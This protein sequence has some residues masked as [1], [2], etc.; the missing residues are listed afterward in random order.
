VAVKGGCLQLEHDSVNRWES[1]AGLL[2]LLDLY[3]QSVTG[4]PT[5]VGALR[6]SIVA[7]TKLV[8][9]AADLPRRW[10]GLMYQLEDRWLPRLDTQ[11]LEAVRRAGT[12]S[13][14]EQLAEM[15]VWSGRLHRHV[16]E[17]IRDVTALMPWSSREFAA[18]AARFG[19]LPAMPSFAELPQ[20]YDLVAARLEEEP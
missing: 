13:D 12:D 1:F 15:A 10:P 17:V 14:H 4:L 19:D 9:E 11:L 3:D 2:T 6:K 5:N 18:A 20:L 8:R 16:Q 7:V